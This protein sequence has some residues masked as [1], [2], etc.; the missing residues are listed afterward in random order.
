[1]AGIDQGEE[2]GGEARCR[3][4]RVPIDYTGFWAESDSGLVIDNMVSDLSLLLVCSL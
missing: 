2:E 3:Y 1:L 4:G